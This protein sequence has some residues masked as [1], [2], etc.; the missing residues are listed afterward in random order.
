M[1]TSALFKRNAALTLLRD[2]HTQ[3]L[4][5]ADR[6][7]R[8]FHISYYYAAINERTLRRVKWHTHTHRCTHINTNADAS[9]KDGTQWHICSEQKG[10]MQCVRKMILEGICCL[11]LRSTHKK[12]TKTHTYTWCSANLKDCRAIT[13]QWTLAQSIPVLFKSS[14]S[15]LRAL[16]PQILSSECVSACLCLWMCICFRRTDSTFQE[17]NWFCFF[18][19][20]RV[21]YTSQLIGFHPATPK[22]QKE[23]GWIILL[24]LIF[25][26]MLSPNIPYYA[27]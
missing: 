16:L 20:T 27:N 15:F 2:R 3:Y 12:D 24:Y 19:R 26:I 11:L 23:G 14:S 6:H 17:Q 9:C 10:H 13:H 25:H 18:F 1:L 7:S 8:W 5:G 22:R 4:D 21:N